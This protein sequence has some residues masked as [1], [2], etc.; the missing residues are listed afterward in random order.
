[1]TL[2]AALSLVGTL[3]TYRLDRKLFHVEQQFT[4]AQQQVLGEGGL[5]IARPKLFSEC[6]VRLIM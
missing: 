1:M 4:P 5:Q 6:K 3:K 2:P